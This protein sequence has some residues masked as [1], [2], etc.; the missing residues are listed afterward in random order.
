MA[1]GSTSFPRDCGYP[2]LSGRPGLQRF[3]IPFAY[4]CA[5]ASDFA[6]A[7]QHRLRLDRGG[8]VL[9]GPTFS[10]RGRKVLGLVLFNCQVVL[11]NRIGSA[12]IGGGCLVGGDQ[13]REILYWGKAAEVPQR[14]ETESECLASAASGRHPLNVRGFVRWTGRGCVVM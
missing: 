14:R 3:V 9:H 5:T 10:I 13:T 12:S 1:A 8:F 4:S 7:E 11:Y 6:L 2:N